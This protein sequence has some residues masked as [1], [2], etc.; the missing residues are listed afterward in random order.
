M[1]YRDSRVFYLGNQRISNLCRN[2]SGA[3]NAGSA[4]AFT[5]I[6]A[7]GSVIWRRA[8]VIGLGLVLG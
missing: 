3:G 7:W 6:I 5:T 2:R 1:D 4:H 8:S